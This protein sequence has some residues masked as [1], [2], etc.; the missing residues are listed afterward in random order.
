MLIFSLTDNDLPVTFL[1]PKF[2]RS[3]KICAS[4]FRTVEFRAT[5]TYG[6]RGWNLAGSINFLRLRIVLVG[7]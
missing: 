7:A 5:P 1:A 2:A 3:R 4:E 6:L